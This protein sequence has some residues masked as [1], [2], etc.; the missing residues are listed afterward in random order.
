M[1]EKD[2]EAVIDEELDKID[3]DEE[4]FDVD[5]EEKIDD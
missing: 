2:I 3:L 1:E 4:D 5:D